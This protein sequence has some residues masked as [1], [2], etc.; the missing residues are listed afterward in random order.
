[1]K[2]FLKIYCFVMGPFAKKPTNGAE[3][4]A[5]ARKTESGRSTRERL[6]VREVGKRLPMAQ[7]AVQK[8]TLYVGGL[9]EEVNESIL[10][11][12][13]IPFGD[14]KDVKT[15]L[16]QATQKHRSFGFVTFLEREDAAA[17]MD[18]MDGAELYGRVLTVNYALPERIKGGEQGW[19]AQPIWADADTWFERQQQEEEMLR[20]Q[21]ENR[22]AMEEAEELHRKKL[23]QEREGEKEETEIKDDPMARAEAEVLKQNN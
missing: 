22:A 18:N 15:P 3:P 13:F 21:A 19:A 2:K 23:A 4:K 5:E 9:A 7:Q 17:A 12:A 14:I 8:N 10:H 6:R 20:I 11:A 16:D 1:M